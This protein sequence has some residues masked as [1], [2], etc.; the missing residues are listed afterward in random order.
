MSQRTSADNLRQT[1]ATA[2]ALLRE[3]TRGR[4]LLEQSG[5]DARYIELYR[6]IGELEQQCTGF[7]GQILAQI[8]ASVVATQAAT[9][10]A[11]MRQRHAE[12]QRRLNQAAT[13]LAGMRG[14]PRLGPRGVNRGDPLA[15]LSSAARVAAHQQATQEE[16]DRVERK[17]TRLVGAREQLNGQLSQAGITPD[18]MKT[19]T[20]QVRLIDS[21]LAPLE[22]RL[23]GLIRSALTPVQT[24]Q[25]NT[26]F[27]SK[28]PLRF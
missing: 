26:R 22:S 4:V 1:L 13:T 16:I 25:Q 7:I 20:A 3:I 5:P 12:Q 23:S 18:I 15:H 28:T 17:I 2:K 27:T 10:L 21:K 14:P 8:R 19:I 11:G 6:Q 24:P 9:T